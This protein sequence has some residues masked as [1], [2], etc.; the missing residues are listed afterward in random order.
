MKVYHGGT[1]VIQR[2]LAGYGRKGLDFG[3]G[4]YVTAISMQAE[5]WADRMARIRNTHGVVNVYD[6]D[7]EKVKREFSYKFFPEYD[8]QWLEFIVQNRLGT[9]HGEEYD[10]VE[11]GVANDRVIDTVEAYM[12]NMMPLETA[13]RNLAMHNPNN[14]LCIRNQRIIDECMV[15]KNLYNI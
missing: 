11:G 12:A 7:M 6:L 9:Y 4:F 14:Q 15:F 3:Q 1:S 13:L 2:P 10:L 8:V 5:A